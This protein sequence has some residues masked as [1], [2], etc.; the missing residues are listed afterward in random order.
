MPTKILVPDF[1]PSGLSVLSLKTKT[2]LFK[3]GASSCM[4][5]LSV[6]I[7]YYLSISQVNAA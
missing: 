5:P 6:K 3:D 4:P 1:I 7:I 2:G